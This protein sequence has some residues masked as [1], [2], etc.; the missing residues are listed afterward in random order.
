MAPLV[1]QQGGLGLKKQIISINFMVG[2]SS[3]MLQLIELTINPNPSGIYDD[4]K[5]LAL[6]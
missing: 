1:P 4:T 6:P 2:L 3:P 5:R